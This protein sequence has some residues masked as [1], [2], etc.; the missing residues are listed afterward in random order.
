MGISHIS[1]RR[2]AKKEL[3]LRSYKLQK[4][5]LLTEKNKLVRL[6]RCR[7]LLKRAARR[8]LR[9]TKFIT[10]K[11]IESG[12]GTLQ[13]PR[14][15][16]NIANIQSRSWFGAEFA[17]VTKHPWLLWKRALNKIKKCT[18]GTLLKQFYFRGTKGISKMQ[19]RCFNK[20]LHEFKKPKRHK[21][22]AR[23]IF[24]DMIS[25]EE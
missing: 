20:T 25:S 13:A 8:S 1:V 15:M 4:V 2:I 23:Q 16:L 3:G 14:Q 24:S 9:F 5:Q 11:T 10:P 19:I 22:A 17:Q 6:R 7:K 21:I 12:V 18:R